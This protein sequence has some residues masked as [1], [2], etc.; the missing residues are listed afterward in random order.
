MS[1]LHLLLKISNVLVYLFFLSATIWSVVG[2]GPD[3][4]TLSKH[5]TYITPAYWVSYVWSLIHFLLGGYI[6]TQWFDAAEESVV[7][8]VGWHFVISTLLNASWLYL[9]TKGHIILSFIAIILVSSSVTY[10]FSNLAYNY[11]ATT[12][13]TKL[14]VHAPF[15]LWH[16]YVVFASV[17]NLFAI[18]TS[19]QDNGPDVFHIILVAF[20]LSF[21]GS[22]AVGYVE[23]KKHK[24]DIVGAL[25]IAW[26]LFAVFANQTNPWIHW[27][28][29]AEGLFAIVY[30][31]RPFISNILGRRA[32]EQAPLLG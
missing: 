31:A 7:Y 15:S 9:W 10:I 16:G 14:F 3:E 22:V 1:R 25:V 8:G 23:F 13:Y 4:D 12:W 21:L 2:P 28:A 18:F 30:S 32:P 20:G 27:I 6:I 5:K 29:F 26:G 11:P 24:G 19:V 17:I